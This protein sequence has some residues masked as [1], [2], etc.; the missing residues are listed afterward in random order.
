MEFLLLYF[1]GSCLLFCS[2]CV[3]VINN[4]VYC[5]LY[6]IL[7]FCNC[8]GIF[9]LLEFDFLALLLLVVYVGAI[10]VLF[11]FV[12]IILSIKERFINKKTY[13]NYSFFGFILGF[14]FCIEVII[15]ITSDVALFSS[16]S[17]NR[18]PVYTSFISIIDSYSNIKVFG[19][20]LYSYYFFFFLLGGLVL[21]V[22]IFGAIIL[23]H[24]N[25]V[26]YFRLEYLVQPQFSIRR[27]KV[28]QQ[29]SRMVNHSV[30][31]VLKKKV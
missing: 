5:V 4:P 6:L 2:F 29:L 8:A 14:L 24:Q 17:W 27:Q 31:L 16:S 22:S 9:L 13:Y 20:V 30:F 3:A 7:G 12:V 10:A 11:L 21:L 28:F 1:F 26:F 15:V 25:G 18:V 19:Q 23:T